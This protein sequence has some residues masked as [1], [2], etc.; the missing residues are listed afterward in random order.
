[1]PKFHEIH[2]ESGEIKKNRFYS[3]ATLSFHMSL[4]SYSFVIDF[5]IYKK[6]NKF[7]TLRSS[8]SVSTYRVWDRLKY[9]RS[10]FTMALFFK[11]GKEMVTITI[12]LRFG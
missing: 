8:R 2:C 5:V 7:F 11:K 6:Q 10:L 12:F 1:M 9:F 3:Q 4:G